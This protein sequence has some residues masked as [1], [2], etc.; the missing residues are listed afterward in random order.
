MANKIVVI[1]L[2]S[3]EEN[4]RAG[5]T[6]QSLEN[7]FNPGDYFD[8]VY[9]LGPK[10]QDIQVGKVHYIK[11]VPTKFAEIINSIKPDIVRAYGGFSCCDWAA[12]SSVKDIPLVISVHDTNPNLINQSLKY[13]DYIICMTKEV[14]RRVKQQVNIEDEKIF[15]MPNRVDTTKFYKRYDKALFAELDKKYGKGKHILHVGRKSEQKNLDT[16]I[17]AL[18]YLP[19]DYSAIFVG[20]GDVKPYVEIAQRYCVEERCFFVDRIGNDELPFYYSWADCMCT[21]SRWEGF[22]FVFI[23]AAACEC[24]IVTSN[25]APL[26]EY[27]T[28]GV[29]CILVDN[30]ENPETLAKQICR[31][32]DKN[33]EIE[34]IKKNARDVGLKF[35]KK[36]VDKQEIDLYQRF[37]SMG[38]DNKK[39]IELEE[40]KKKIKRDVIIFGAGA[41]G[42][43]LLEDIGKAAYFVDN[44]K[45]KIGKYINGVKVISFENLVEIHKEYIIIVTPVNRKEIVEQLRQSNIDYIEA[46]WYRLLREGKL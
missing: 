5:N 1:P 37:I 25:I 32:S 35:D 44:D 28:D 14:K 6:Y 7:Y 23:E 27:L 4:L 16:L 9:C 20:Q 8:E 29:N 43:K 22:G 39:L 42:Q 10:E 24:L 21:P 31:V 40:E 18:M 26:N 11:A 19:E 3:T 36:Q 33:K 45:N 34:K 41:I 2:N 17:K 46:D 15:V 13:G 30:Y 38:T 12:A